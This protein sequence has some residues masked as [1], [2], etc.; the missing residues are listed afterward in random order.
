MAILLEELD[1][2]AISDA[3]ESASITE[4]L[5]IAAPTLLECHIVIFGRKRERGIEELELLLNNTKTTK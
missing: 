4:D 1:A 5:F 3:I 2:P